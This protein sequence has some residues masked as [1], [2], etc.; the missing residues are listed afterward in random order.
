MSQE[1][2][3]DFY[4]NY[5]KSSDGQALQAKL[6]S[7]KDGDEFLA[8]ATEGGKAAGF[9]FT[10]DEVREVMRAAEARM[11]KEAAE[12]QGEELSDEQLE[13][14]AGGAYS[15]SSSSLKISTMP[16]YLD[17]GKLE[18]STVMCPW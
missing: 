17:S 3:I 18:Y 4:E 12:A 6:N 14:V 16:S 13:N 7:V 5:L 8:V 2:Y 11:A 10:K 9:D 1:S 15:L